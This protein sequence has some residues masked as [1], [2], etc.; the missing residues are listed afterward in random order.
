[1]P[2]AGF[3]LRGASCDGSSQLLGLCG[4]AAFQLLDVIPLKK[5]IQ[6]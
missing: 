5:G 2:V 3:E 4:I 1:M 6:D